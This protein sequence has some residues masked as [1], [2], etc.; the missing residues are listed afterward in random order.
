MSFPS[1]QP[2]PNNKKPPVVQQFQLAHRGV[3]IGAIQARMVR[4]PPANSPKIPELYRIKFRESDRYIRES[5][6]DAVV[7]YLNGSSRQTREEL[8]G[9]S[10]KVTTSSQAVVDHLDKAVLFLL[11]PKVSRPVRVRYIPTAAATNS[12]Y[13]APSYKLDGYLPHLGI[14]SSIV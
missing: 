8:L 14:V 2:Q 4:T 10:D 5:L 9:T 1:V 11:D 12:P 6:A 13:T 3:P 7:R